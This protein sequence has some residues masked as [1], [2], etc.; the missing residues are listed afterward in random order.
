MGLRE[1]L[2]MMGFPVPPGVTDE[3]I[4]AG[5]QMASGPAPAIDG[6]PVRQFEMEN[7]PNVAGQGVDGQD[8]VERF[9]DPGLS[10]TA[11]PSF[12]NLDGAPSQDIDVEPQGG[13]QYG[14]P[15]EELTGQQK[16]ALDKYKRRQANTLAEKAGIT[17]QQAALSLDQTLAINGVDISADGNFY[18]DDTKLRDAAAFGEAEE[19]QNRQAAVDARGPNRGIGLNRA[20]SDFFMTQLTPEQRELYKQGLVT[21]QQDRNNAA[22]YADR[23]AGRDHDMNMQTNQQDFIGTQAGL[24]RTQEEKV[25]LPSQERQKQT[26]AEGLRG[27]GA[28]AAGLTGASNETIAVTEKERDIAVAKEQNK[29]QGISPDTKAELDQQKEIERPGIFTSYEEDRTTGIN[30][31]SNSGGF[32][33][34][35]VFASDQ[36][37][38]PEEVTSLSTNLYNKYG[39]V[40]GMTREEIEQDIYNDATV[41]GVRT[42][43][44]TGTFLGVP[45]YF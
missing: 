2:E 45:M 25:T 38:S 24:D 28:E 8:S 21:S 1:Q 32:L 13:M 19:Q 33:G 39:K 43:P 44:P 9:P 14:V 22:R 42:K 26:E 27:T 11:F 3:E 40:L 41:R 17:P 7:T 10:N 18:I 29:P 30:K 12:D 36:Y 6:V 35:G 34:T 5:L 23:A 16:R 31:A 15:L 20:G 4:A 37:L